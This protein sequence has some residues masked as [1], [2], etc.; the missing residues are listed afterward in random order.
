MHTRRLFTFSLDGKTEIPSSPPPA[1]ATP[2]DVKDFI[3]DEKKVAQ[4]KQ[5]YSESCSL[6]HGG[7]VVS[8]GMATD[9]RES[10]MVMTK[11]SFRAVLVDGASIQKGMPRFKDYGEEELT[12][13][14]HYIR[15]RARYSINN[16][17]PLHF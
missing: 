17:S 6:C 3:L 5:L 15:E 14:M 13:L 12:S 2:V 9:L 7:G 11:E 8:G 16:P 4:G 10:P 1:Y